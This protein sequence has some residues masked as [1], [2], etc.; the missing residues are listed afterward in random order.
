MLTDR[1]TLLFRKFFGFLC[2]F[3]VTK[4]LTTSVYRQERIGPAG[5]LST[6]ILARIRHYVAE[7]QRHWTFICSQWVCIQRQVY[8][9]TNLMRFS[10]V[11]L[12]HPIGPT[13]FDSPMALLPEATV[14]TSL[15]ILRAK[16]LHCDVTA[17]KVAHKR[18]KMAQRRYNG[19][20]DTKMCNPP[21]MFHTVQYGQIDCPPMTTSVAERMAASF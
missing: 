16:L 9:S 2:P 5:R 20:H 11:L 10:Q 1:K 17:G 3:L 18:L 12:P 21:Q 14:T 6:T 19:H 4:L 8:R 15:R 7:N 13:T